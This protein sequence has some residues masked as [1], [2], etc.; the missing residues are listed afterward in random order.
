MG[1]LQPK[2]CTDTRID[3][4][5]IDPDV[6]KIQKVLTKSN[7][8]CYLVGGCIRDL[9]CEK[10]PKDFDLV[11]NATPEQ[12]I[13]I[14]KKKARLV[15]RRFPIVHVR[16][17]KL[18][19]EVSTFRGPESPDIKYGK[20]GIILTDKG[21]GKIEDDVF[22]RD[23]T[24]NALYYDPN[25]NHILDYLG[26]LTD[27]ENK[28]LRFIGKARQRI[29]EDPLRLLRAI[30]FSAKLEMNLDPELAKVINSC[31]HQISSVSK[32]RLFDEFKKLFL[33]GHSINTWGLLKATSIVDLLWPDC[34]KN[35]PLIEHGLQSAD[36]RYREN[37]IINPAFI[38]ALLLWPT[39]EER[40]KSLKNSEEESMGKAILKL[41]NTRMSIP[42]RYSDFVLNIW[43]MQKH[44]T[45]NLNQEK[46]HLIRKRSFRA[47]YDFLV[48]RAKHEKSLHRASIFWT[49]IQTEKR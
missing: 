34:K 6:L 30:R 20:S 49:D 13:K 44:L 3:P 8:D 18:L 37:K 7:F 24:I 5:L 38:I 12:V 36:V 47:S 1:L 41:Q 25:N 46:Y 21:Y 29:E 28:N 40:T 11:T 15:G 43:L 26:G 9:I 23:F 19:V 16:S 2:I 35:H 33:S 22:R 42:R 39:F 14:F 32:P 17:G 48:L 45:T 4:S 31:V 27:L 10:K